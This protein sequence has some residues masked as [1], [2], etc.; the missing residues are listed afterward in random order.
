M[1]RCSWD[2][3]F[4]YESFM[5]TVPSQSERARIIRIV[6]KYRDAARIRID[7]PLIFPRVL[8]EEQEMYAREVSTLM[9]LDWLTSD[10]NR[11]LSKI[12]TLT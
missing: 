1:I 9:Y 4:A 11:P 6:E 5:L 7:S 8:S 10:E 3:L 12:I 2:D